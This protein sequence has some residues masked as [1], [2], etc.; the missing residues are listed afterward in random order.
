MICASRMWIV[1]ILYLENEFLPFFNR[2]WT[3]FFLW[4]QLLYGRDHLNIW[5]CLCKG[6]LVDMLLGCHALAKRFWLS[7]RLVVRAPFFSA[8]LTGRFGFTNRTLYVLKLGSPLGSR[9]TLGC[10]FFSFKKHTHMG[11]VCACYGS[12]CTC[13]SPFRKGW[14]CSHRQRLEWSLYYYQF[15]RNH[16]L[17]YNAL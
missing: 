4:K 3:R 9:H 2:L 1:C 7:A 6:Q 13:L 8:L 15:W 17:A 14:L 10:Y 16:I 5:L 12:W 11:C